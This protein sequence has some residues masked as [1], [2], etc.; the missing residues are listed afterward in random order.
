[1]AELHK[2]L[3]KAGS[4]ALYFSGIHHITRPIHG[5]AGA[6]L[7]VHHVRRRNRMAF[8]PRRNLEISPRFLD[9]L[10]SRLRRWNTDIVSLD[11]M[12]ARLTGGKQ[13]RRF[14]CFT[15]DGAYKDHKESAW[16]IF[17][18]HNAPFALFVPTSFPDRHGELWWLALEELFAKTD[19]IVLLINGREQRI[20][21][22]RVSEKAAAYD[23]LYAYLMRRDTDDEI[24]TTVRDLARRYQIDIPPLC[25]RNCMSWDDIGEMAQDPLCTVGAHSVNYPVPSKISDAKI[26]SEFR[27]SRAVI[28][29]ALGAAPAHLAYPFGERG[30]VG[31]REFRI[32]SELGFKTALTARPG[33][34]HARDANAPYALPRIPLRGDRQSVHYLRMVLSGMPGFR[35]RAA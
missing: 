16:P 4:R 17:K 20:E 9:A 24:R 32:A 33:L 13:K 1:M 22:S 11:E 23:E 18:K 15:L 28:E 14:V 27:M 29:G 19:E 5:G 8:A 21:C 30:T 2:T 31:E 25:E 12:H 35:G 6:I 10:L 26:A 34:I 3:V 7:S